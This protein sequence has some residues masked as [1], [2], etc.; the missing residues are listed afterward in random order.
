M[1]ALRITEVAMP[2]LTKVS[3][4]LAAALL[5][6]NREISLSD[7]RALPFVESDEDVEQVLG[8]LLHSFRV[9]RIQRRGTSSGLP[10]WEDILQLQDS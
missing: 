4:R 3:T 10:E 9:E 7:I 1:L 5:L 6:R 8:T 2:D